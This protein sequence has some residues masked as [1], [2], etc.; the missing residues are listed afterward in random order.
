MLPGDVPPIEALV[1]QHRAAVVVIDPVL[2]YVDG[3]LNFHRD[4]DTRQAIA[5][6]AAMTGRTGCTV[7]LVRH[8]NKTT[9]TTAPFRGAAS[10]A[11]VA[12]SAWRCWQRRTP[13]CRACTCS[14]WSRTASRRWPR[15]WPTP[16]GERRGAAVIEWGGESQHGAD[17]LVIRPDA[18]ER[19]AI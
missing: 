9:G 1:R 5:P 18:E 10:I 13:T 12:W 17:D 7:M 6:L 15:R 11:F 4:Q 2:A 3:K 8:L 16:I 14:R 19:S